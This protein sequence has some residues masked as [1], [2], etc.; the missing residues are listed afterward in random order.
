[1]KI[2]IGRISVDQLIYALVL[3]GCG[4]AVLAQELSNWVAYFLLL[5]AVVVLFWHRVKR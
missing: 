3:G 5:L 4:V 2:R 1:M